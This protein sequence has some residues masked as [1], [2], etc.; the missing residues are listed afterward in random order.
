MSKT[1]EEK[2]IAE[3]LLSLGFQPHLKGYHF[4][5]AAIMEVRANNTIIYGGIT[6]GLYPAIAKKFNCKPSHVERAIRHS[7]ECAMST[8]S[9]WWKQVFKFM[10]ST[11]KPT[12]GEFLATVAEM[13][14]LKMVG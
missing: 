3:M 9:P 5:L 7:I 11:D 2:E 6:K 12:N 4:T 10:P 14:R 13:V 8:L 1:T